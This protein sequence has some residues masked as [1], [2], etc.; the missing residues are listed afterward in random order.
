MT[1]VVTVLMHQAHRMAEPASEG[2]GGGFLSINVTL[3]I[4]VVLV[5]A[6][7]RV[8]D[9]VYFQPVRRILAERYRLTYGQL[10]E[11]QELLHQIE[12]EQKRYETAIQEMH[13]YA[14]Q[15]M[16]AARATA[17]QQR[18]AMID[19][20]RAETHVQI[21]RTRAELRQQV[22]EAKRV[23]EREADRLA[24]AIAERILQ[25]P[26]EVSADQMEKFRAEL[27]EVVS[28]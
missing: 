6:F 21:E 11:A 3:A 13:Q 24:L 7:W 18:A 27:Q 12:S 28:G 22:E 25:R 17:E 26:L 4:V 9:R 10:E 15:R 14:N 23:L 5:W 1:C 2:G 19:R 8:L 20:T 16:A